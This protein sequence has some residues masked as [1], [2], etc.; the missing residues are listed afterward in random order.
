MTNL[1]YPLRNQLRISYSSVKTFHACPRKFE[2]SK[3]YNLVREDNAGHAAS[4]G[5]LLHNTLAVWLRTRDEQQALNYMCTHYPVDTFK[6]YSASDPRSL[7]ACYGTMLAMFDHPLFDRLE[8]SKINVQGTPTPAIEVPFEIH[9]GVQ[10]GNLPLS[11]IGY[12]DFICW[13]RHLQKHIILDLKTTRRKFSH[14]QAKFRFDEQMLPYSLILETVLGMPFNLVD[15]TYLYT[16]I[17]LL[18][19]LIEPLTYELTRTHV[20]EWAQ[21]LYILYTE[22]QLYHQHRWFPRRSEACAGYGVCQFLPHCDERDMSFLVPYFEKG[23][24]IASEVREFTPWFTAR[25]ELK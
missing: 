1:P 10:V 4:V 22:L 24:Y 5:H 12:I 25:V 20:Q 14:M 23:G 3:L 21:D 8:L 7:E 17:D 19:P 13:D 2:F 9:L 15:V 16:Y 6:A 11:F 18:E